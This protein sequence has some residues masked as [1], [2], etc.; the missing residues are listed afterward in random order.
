MKSN[1]SD[2]K[3]NNTKSSNKIS[4]AK[5][6]EEIYKNK[7]FGANFFYC[8]E[9]EH[10][11]IYLLGEDLKLSAL[12]KEEQEI[13]SLPMLNHIS[14]FFKEAK[15]N[16]SYDESSPIITLVNQRK[17]HYEGLYKNFKKKLDE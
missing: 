4:L 11:L 7:E 9:M 5:I 14:L 1:T 6:C 12:S 17:E 15:K 10:K 8:E 13:L 16:D 2:N 3:G